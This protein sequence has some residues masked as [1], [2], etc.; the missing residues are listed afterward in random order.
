MEP[1]TFCCGERDKPEEKGK[2]AGEDMQ[3][4]YCAHELV[5]R[6]AG[7]AAMMCTT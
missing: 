6:S 1:R 2:T 5:R 3:E 4:H 7:L